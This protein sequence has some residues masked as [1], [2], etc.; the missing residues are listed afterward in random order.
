MRHSMSKDTAFNQVFNG[1]TTQRHTILCSD[2]QC[3]PP[4][5]PK[6]LCAKHEYPITGKSSIAQLDNS[7]KIHFLE[8]PERR[9]ATS[10]DSLEGALTRVR[11]NPVAL[12]IG[13]MTIGG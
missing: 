1:E 5:D 9:T 3:L 7:I 13:S 8:I 12:V 2:S 10:S 11:W 4:S 6:I